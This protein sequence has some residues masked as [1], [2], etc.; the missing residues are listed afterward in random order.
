MPWC[1]GERPVARLVQT[2]GE[3]T[4]ST[5]ARSAV[6]PRF[7][8]AA[9]AAGYSYGALLQRIV[10]LGLKREALVRRKGVN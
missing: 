7:A 8:S 5:V 9:N 1:S 6:T 3:T 10:N 2:T 4:G